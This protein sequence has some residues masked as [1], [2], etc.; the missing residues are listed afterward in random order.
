MDRSLL[1]TVVDSR[2][3]RLERSV[4]AL[5]HVT[6]LDSTCAGIQHQ[7]TC[8]HHILKHDFLHRCPG[9]QLSLWKEIIESSAR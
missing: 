8:D 1:G 3:S 6:D 4:I 5:D 7:N 2:N 9:S